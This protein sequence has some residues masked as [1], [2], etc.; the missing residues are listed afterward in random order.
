MTVI[1]LTA[2][3]SARIVAK[4]SKPGAF[5]GRRFETIVTARD[6]QKKLI[7]KAISQ[8]G[9]QLHLRCV[10][11]DAAKPSRHD[12]LVWNS[13]KRKRTATRARLSDIRVFNPNPSFRYR[14]IA[15][16]DDTVAFSIEAF[17]GSREEDASNSRGRPAPHK[18]DRK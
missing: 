11:I 18:S 1:V 5:S 7:K 9:S 13:Q 10:S 6:H 8:R 16:C 4:T 14:D 3:R 17:N 15:I 12:G 2:E